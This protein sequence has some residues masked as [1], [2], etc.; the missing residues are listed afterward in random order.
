MQTIAELDEAQLIA[1]TEPELENLIDIE[2]AERGIP[3]LPPEPV[4]PEEP[5]IPYDIVA[6]SIG[7]WEFKNREDAEAVAALVNGKPRAKYSYDYKLADNDFVGWT[8]EERAQIAEKPI[9]S[10]V[11][12]LAT[13]ADRLKHKAAKDE[14]DRLRNEHREILDK[15]AEVGDEVRE[16]YWAALRRQRARDEHRAYFARYLE[17]ANGD[18]RVAFRFFE[19]SYGFILQTY[20]ELRAELEPPPVEAAEAECAA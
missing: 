18:R 8:I 17:M 11:Q 2:C 4:L 5:L 3:M 14:Y 6:F 7:H 13:K 10:A 16:R 15:R 19:K 1:L 20:P 9:L 12:R